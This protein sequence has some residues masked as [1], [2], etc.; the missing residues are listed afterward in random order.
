MNSRDS[1]KMGTVKAYDLK[2]V[3]LKSLIAQKQNVEPACQKNNQVQK[4][5]SWKGSR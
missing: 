3:L 1:E 4:Q 2:G 5:T